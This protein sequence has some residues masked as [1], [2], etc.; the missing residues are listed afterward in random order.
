MD[1]GAIGW[2]RVRHDWSDL[3]YLHEWYGQFSFHI[4]EMW[5]IQTEQI[6]IKY[7]KTELKKKQMQVNGNL[8]RL[9]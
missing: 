1:R 6:D 2:Q 3:V 9:N 7:F 5:A 4:G 8:N